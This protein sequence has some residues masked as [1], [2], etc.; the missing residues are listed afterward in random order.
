V[1]VLV[2]RRRHAILFLVWFFLSGKVECVH[3]RLTLLDPPLHTP[4]DEGSPK[5]SSN[6]S[7]VCV[8][9]NVKRE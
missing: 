3:S 7:H 9:S 5:K 6:D 1:F 2:C 8:P 4:T